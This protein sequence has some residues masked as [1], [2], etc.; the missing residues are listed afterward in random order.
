MSEKRPIIAGSTV[1]W[2]CSKCYEWYYPNDF[3]PDKRAKNGLQSQCKRCYDYTKKVTTNK[4][5]DM[6]LKRKAARKYYRAYPERWKAKLC[7]QVAIKNGTI[8]RPVTC[9]KCGCTGKIEGHHRDYNK[10][11]DVVWLCRRCHMEEHQ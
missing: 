4:Q 8:E 10:P 2:K 9:S 11:L 1:L 3:Y 5:N 7:V 6:R